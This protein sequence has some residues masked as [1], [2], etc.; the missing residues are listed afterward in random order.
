MILTLAGQKGGTG[1]STLACHLAVEWSWRGCRVLLVDTDSQ[2]TTLRWGELRAER[3]WEYPTVIPA[4]ENVREAVKHLSRGFD[5]TIIDTPGRQS[6]SCVGSLAISNLA[7]LPCP[8]SGPDI[9]ALAGSIDTAREVQELYPDLYLA[10]VLNGV[11]KTKL[12]KASQAAIESFSLP[13]IARLGRRT[14]LA[15]AITAGKGIR[16]Y[17]SGSM[18]ALEIRSLAD[19]IEEIHPLPTEKRGGLLQKESAR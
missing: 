19:A 15:E 14:Q 13:T 1:K 4:G 18:A 7:L 16:E 12:S 8:P 9:W 2:A 17:R 10:L 6:K 11:Q 3:G 5:V